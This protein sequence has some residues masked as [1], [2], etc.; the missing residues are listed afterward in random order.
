MTMKAVLFALACALSTACAVGPVEP[1]L[2]DSKEVK[3]D[4]EFCYQFAIGFSEAGDLGV[5]VV[6]DFTASCTEFASTSRAFGPFETFAEA[7]AVG[8]EQCAGESL[9]DS[10]RGFYYFCPA[11]YQGSLD[12]PCLQRAGEAA[13]ASKPGERR[14]DYAQTWAKC[15]DE[16]GYGR[17]AG[18]PDCFDVDGPSVERFR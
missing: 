12:A 5:S 14:Q 9:L 8:A 3:A 2:A 4:H 10:R 15:Y 13:D 6:G 11:P 18:A 17:P 7:E 16:C 1:T